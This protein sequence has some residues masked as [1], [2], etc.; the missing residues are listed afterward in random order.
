MTTPSA[1]ERRTFTATEDAAAILLGGCTFCLGLWMVLS[2]YAMEDNPI[3]SLSGGID[4]KQYPTWL[5]VGLMLLSALMVGRAVLRRVGAGSFGFDEMRGMLP[6]G[7]IAA[8][9]AGL[10]LYVLAFR[11]LGYIL[12]TTLY[13][14]VLMRAAGARRWVPT[15][16]FPGALALALY[17]LVRLVFDIHLPLGR[18]WAAVLGG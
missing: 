9:I 13:G 17:W 3:A 18:L 1:G 15:V 8:V 12:A 16:I 6:W 11:W 10:F 7:R 5:G 2:I 4:A 14:A